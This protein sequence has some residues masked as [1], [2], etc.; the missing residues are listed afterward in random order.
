MANPIRLTNKLLVC[1]QLVVDDLAALNA[2]GIRT[3]ICNRPDDEGAG[4]PP[5]DNI[6]AAAHQLGMTFTHIPVTA[7]IEMSSEAVTQFDACLEASAGEAVAYCR[8]GKRS[9]IMWALAQRGKMPVKEILRT[10]AQSGFDLGGLADRLAP[11]ATSSHP[12][13]P[14]TAARKRGFWSRLWGNG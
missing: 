1:P 5:A 14:E 11:D 10:T 2:N 6:A 3:I 7:K 4:Q 12:P 8:T 13:G 9:A